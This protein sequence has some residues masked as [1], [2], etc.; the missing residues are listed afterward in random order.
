[1]GKTGLRAYANK[2]DASEAA[3]V[4][5]LRKAGC[6]VIRMDKPVD[7]LVGFRG[8]TFLVEVKTG[9]GKLNEGQSEF[10]RQWRGAPVFVV[11]DTDGAL[12]TLKMWGALRGSTSAR[13]AA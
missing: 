9:K 4:E 2:R 11:R 7:L 13:A 3:I 12:E 1:M 5:V 8:G 6:S 10:I